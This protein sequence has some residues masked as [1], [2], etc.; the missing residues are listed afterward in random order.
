MPLE[1]RREGGEARGSLD[2]TPDHDHDVTA[3]A[4]HAI[5]LA[6]SD[7]PVGEEL[8]PELTED[9]VESLVSERQRPGVG[10]APFDRG[11]T[12][13]RERSGNGKHARIEINRDDHPALA[14]LLGRDARDHARATRDI[15]HP[16]TRPEICQVDDEPRPRS[17][18]SRDEVAFVDVWRAG[19]H[20]PLGSID[21][22]AASSLAPHFPR[23]SS[24]APGIGN[25]SNR[26]AT[27]ARI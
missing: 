6:Q 22:H 1:R 7:P 11:T 2:R 24:G 18:H 14:H 12:W 15:E 4:Q 16:V 26:V 8:K 20:L 21:H 10:L 9:D 19:A 23:H 27:M 5:H 3:W 25:S 17:E 13:S